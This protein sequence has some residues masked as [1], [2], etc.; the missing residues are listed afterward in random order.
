MRWTLAL[1]L[2][3]ACAAPRRNDPEMEGWRLV[4]LGIAQDGGMPHLG[5]T[6]PP[7]SDARAGRSRD[8]KVSCIGVVHRGLGLAYLFDASPDLPAQVH[9]LTGGRAPDGIFLTHG[10]IGH[11][12][13]L[14]YLGKETMAARGVPVHATES[15]EGFLASNGPWS[16]LARD[17]HISPRRLLPDRMVE[18]PGGLRVTPLLVPHRAEFTD[19]VGFLIE[20]PRRKALFLPDIDTWELWDRSLAEIADQVDLLYVDGTFASLEELPHRD[21]T[22]VRH[23][24]MSETRRI[25]QGRR[26]RLRFLH[27][28]HTNPCLITGGDDVAREGEEED[29]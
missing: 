5:C 23:P 8:E 7:C 13:G 2:F 20:G 4:V 29:L 6:K 28:N 24:L 3:A 21:I 19:T 15:M 1:L 26:A 12:T 18:L 11:Y 9:A 10:H 25:V 16:L 27:L 17:G 22:K 14:M